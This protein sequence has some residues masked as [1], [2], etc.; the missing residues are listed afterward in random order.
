MKDTLIYFFAGADGLKKT[1][2]LVI[3]LN[4]MYTVILDIHVLQVTVVERVVHVQRSYQQYLREKYLSS[5]CN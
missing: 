5:Y 2:K 1:Y 4:D 3:G